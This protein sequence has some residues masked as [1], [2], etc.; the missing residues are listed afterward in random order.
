MKAINWSKLSSIAEIVSS[1]AVIFTLVYLAIQT[2]QTNELLEVQ[3]SATYKTSRS[4]MAKSVFSDPEMAKLLIN[5]GWGA[6]NFG[7]LSA[8]DSL[9]A[10]FLADYLFTSWEWDLQQSENGRIRLPVYSYKRVATVWPVLRNVWPLI[11]SNYSE[12]FQLFM[13]ENVFRQ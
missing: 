2:S 6:P 10:A 8:E 7:D 9:R 12:E 11:K 5:S 3:A 4:E 13:D 1:I